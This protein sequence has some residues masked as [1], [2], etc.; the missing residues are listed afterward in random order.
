MTELALS[1]GKPKIKADYDQYDKEN[2]LKL[3]NLT[4]VSHDLLVILIFFSV[5][6]PI[7]W[8]LHFKNII[9]TSILKVFK[10][11]YQF[12]TAVFIGLTLN[13]KINWDID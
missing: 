5:I 11:V 13:G 1:F 2:T 8:L 12:D 7:F 10:I 4:L 9:K 3:H 6:Y